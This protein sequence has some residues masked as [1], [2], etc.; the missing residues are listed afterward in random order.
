MSD[1]LFSRTEIKQI[2]VL[3]RLHLYNQG[4]PCG[5]NSIRQIMDR[6][7]VRPLP[8]I[9]TIKRILSR[10]YLTYGRTGLYP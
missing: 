10:H 7:S 2:V 6:D 8:S 1:Q 3:E 4:F 5:A 9:T